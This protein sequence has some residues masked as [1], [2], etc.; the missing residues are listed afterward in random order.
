MSQSVTTLTT[1]LLPD[2][3][4]DSVSNSIAWGACEVTTFFDHV[5]KRLARL[6]GLFVARSTSITSVQGTATYALASRHLSTI[7]VTFDGTPLVPADTHSL[8]MKTGAFETTQGVPKRYYQDK[9]TLDRIGLE[10]VP[11]AASDSKTVA[12]IY[13][14]YPAELDCAGANTTIPVPAVIGDYLETCVLRECYGKESDLACP[15]IAQHLLQHTAL[16]EQVIESYWG[17]AA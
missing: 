13:H 5:L 14:E 15:E 1:R 7:R 16:I 2:L 12:V 3:H 11:N 9:I 8:S 4:T 10:P 17:S 6:A